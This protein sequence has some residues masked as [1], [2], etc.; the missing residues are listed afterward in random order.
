MGV[1][2]AIYGKIIVDD[3][4]LPDG[5]LARSVLGGGGPQAAFGARLWSDSVGLLTRT[6]TDLEAEHADTLRGLEVDLSGWRQFPD[7]PTPRYRLQYDDEEYLAGGG[8]MTTPED[9][10]RLLA[11]PLDL[12]PAY[13]HPLAIHLITEFPREPMV[14]TA[15]ELRAQG[16]VLSLEPLAAGPSRTDWKG[17]L[18]QFRQVDLVT[19]DWPTATHIAASDDP[20][21]VMRHWSTLGPALV[22]VRHG[23]HG[24]YVWS[25]ERDETWHILPV[26]TQVVDP[27][28]AGN[29]YGGGL[30]VG[31]TETRD[32]RLAGCYGAIAA[33]MLVRHVGLPRMSHVLRQAAQAQLE[34]AVR[35]ALLM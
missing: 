32:A 34:H 1:D 35:A 8:L 31:W 4:P 15:L 20:R 17:M 5:G 21:Q 29:A 25:R 9:W 22:A 33:S 18:A 2:Y 26:P 7:I 10:T 12:P 19:P 6:G 24:S 13:L 3:V 30:V 14:E 16:T 11:R 28:G 27:T 23:A